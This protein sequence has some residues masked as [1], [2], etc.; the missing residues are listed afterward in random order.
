MNNARY[1][2]EYAA[3]ARQ[4]MAKALASLDVID[5]MNDTLLDK[6]STNDMSYVDDYADHAASYSRRTVEK[7]VDYEKEYPGRYPRTGNV[8]T[9]PKAAKQVLQA[10]I[11][12]RRERGY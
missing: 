12:R 11:K 4:N 10:E 6:L 7:A 1:I 8:K 5:S 3:K 2:R 9:D